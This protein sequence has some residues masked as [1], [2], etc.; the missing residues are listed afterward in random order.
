MDTELGR[1]CRGL[2]L[3]VCLYLIFR[4]AN[5]IRI[6][7]LRETEKLEAIFWDDRVLNTDLAAVATMML[8]VGNIEISSTQ[9][10]PPFQNR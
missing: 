10:L 9:V 8:T 4:P 2:L 6:I 1:V 5:V 3:Q 7:W